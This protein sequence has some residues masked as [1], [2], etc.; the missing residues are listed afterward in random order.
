MIHTNQSVW[1][2]AMSPQE[3][4]NSKTK[5]LDAALGVIR[6]KGYTAT[7]VDDICES[8]GVTKG[9]FFHHFKTKDELALAAAAHFS[10]MADGVFAAAP[11][12]AAKDPAQRVL[13][14][15]DFRAAMLGRE[16][17]EYTCLLG[18]MVQE[19]Y[20][21]HPAI[22]AACDRYM[23]EHTQSLIEDIAEAKALHAPDAK[24]SPES[25]AF[26]TQTVLQGSF[27]FSKAKQNN[28]VAVDSLAL[29]RG[30]LAMLFNQ[31]QS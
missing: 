29:L 13:G 19:T 28:K 6:S 25:V 5:L 12:H 9:S 8:A 1:T 2:L 20:L 11:Y 21:T 23:S 14:Y 27:I 22:R 16:I 10:D 3:R 24:W 7:T 18:T 31:P 4:Q 30:H 15:I 17:P 26:Y